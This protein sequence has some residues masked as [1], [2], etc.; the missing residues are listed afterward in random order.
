MRSN[1]SIE[2]TAETSQRFV[3]FE[4]VAAR[5]DFVELVQLSLEN[6]AVAQSRHEFFFR[7]IGTSQNIFQL[8]QGLGFSWTKIWFVY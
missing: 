8:D 6:G 3:A 4:Q 7:S 1:N 5:R 2:R